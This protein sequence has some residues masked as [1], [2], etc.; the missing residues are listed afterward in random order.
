LGGISEPQQMAV[1][2]I[3]I[4]V[5]WNRILLYLSNFGFSVNSPLFAAA[6]AAKAADAT[7]SSSL[8]LASSMREM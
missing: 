7:T 6:A 5:D 1:R 4:S 2:A 3:K 8:F